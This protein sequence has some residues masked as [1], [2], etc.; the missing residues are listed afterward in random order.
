MLLLLLFLLFYPQVLQSL[1]Y[2]NA[3]TNNSV[4]DGNRTVQLRVTDSAGAIS[5]TVTVIVVVEDRNDEP[6]VMIDDSITFEEGGNSIEIVTQHLV[7]IMDEEMNNISSIDITLSSPNGQLDQN[8][9]LFLRTPLFPMLLDAMVTRTQITLDAEG[10]VE[11][12][13]E[14]LRAV[15]YINQ[16][17]EPTCF[18]NGEERLQRVLTVMITDNNPVTPSTVTHIIGISITLINDN[19]PRLVL[20]SDCPGPL[21]VGIFSSSPF[22]SLH[23]RDTSSLKPHRML[24]LKKKAV[25]GQLR[26]VRH[27]TTFFTLL[28]FS[29]LLFRVQ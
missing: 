20:R 19:A 6:T 27:S 11:Q 4:A 9:R 18:V 3:F 10:T 15:R 7:D 5:N 28:I 26:P 23:K 24:Q 13:E 25:S 8:E 2:L 14:V 17:D 16:E 1:R 22:T 29:P 21:P 12:Y